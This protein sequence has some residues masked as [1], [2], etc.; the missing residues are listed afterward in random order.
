M[1]CSFP[2]NIKE[3]FSGLWS[4]GRPWRPFICKYICQFQCVHIIKDRRLIKA[5]FRS[6]CWG[7]F[8]WHSP[9]NAQNLLSAFSSGFLRFELHFELAE[10]YTFICIWDACGCIFTHGN[11]S[12]WCMMFTRFNVLSLISQCFSW[13]KWTF[14]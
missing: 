5:D 2:K 11:K 1:K 7:L 3:L 10:I 4:D 9:I 8:I 12:W 14:A 6:E 13:S